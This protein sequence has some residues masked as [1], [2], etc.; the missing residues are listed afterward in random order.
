MPAHG[1]SKNVPLI[2]GPQLLAPN[3]GSGGLRPASHQ[4]KE[5][6]SCAISDLMTLVAAQNEV[7]ETIQMQV[8]VLWIENGKIWKTL[9]E[10][11]TLVACKLTEAQVKLAPNGLGRVLTTVKYA[12]AMKERKEEVNDEKVAKEAQRLAAKDQSAAALW[13]RIVIAQLK[14]RREADLGKWK[15][16]VAAWEETKKSWV[17]QQGKRMPLKPKRPPMPKEADLNGDEGWEDDIAASIVSGAVEGE[18]A[19]EEEE[20]FNLTSIDG[21]EE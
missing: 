12:A 18:D 13:K 2:F 9:Y 7:I 19:H 21:E 3:W 11:E 6:M 17:P 16:E 8:A 15:E 5:E 14:K 20:E 4:T 10:K 1:T